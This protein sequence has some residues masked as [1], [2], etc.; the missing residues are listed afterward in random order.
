MITTIW[1]RNENSLQKLKTLF[2]E[3]KIPLTYITKWKETLPNITYPAMMEECD[4]IIDL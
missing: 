4:N 2:L 1:T 3:N